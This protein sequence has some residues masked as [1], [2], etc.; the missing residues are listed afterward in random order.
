MVSKYIL[1]MLYSALI[2]AQF[3][4]KAVA[5]ANSIFTPQVEENATVKTEGE[6]NFSE[7]GSDERSAPIISGQILES[8][9]RTEAK[10]KDS[11]PRPAQP[12]AAMTEYILPVPVKVSGS[13]I[14]IKITE[15][16]AFSQAQIDA[17]IS[18]IAQRFIDREITHNEFIE[19]LKEAVNK[20]TQ[21]YRNNGYIYA[22]ARPVSTP[23][24]DGS[25]VEI[26]VSEGRISEVI[27]QGRQR[28]NL[29]YICSR[30][31]G[32][33]GSPFST[34][35][36]E[37]KLRLLRLDP[38]LESVQANLQL[39]IENKKTLTVNVKEAK[40]FA[41][42]V[43]FDNYFPPSVGSERVGIN[44][45]YQN[46]TGIGDEIVG[47]YFRT[48]SGGAE[49]LDLSYRLPVNPSNGTLQGRVAVNQNKI[50]QS[51]FEDLGIR[52][53][54][55]LYQF[56]YRQPIV[57]STEREFAVIGGF[58]HQDGQTFI[59]D[60]TPVP[61]GIGPDEKGVSRT[62]VILF[63]QDYVSRSASGSWSVRSQF[64]LG[65]GLFD[66]TT[67]N[68]PIPDGHFFKWNGQVQR[69]QQL[70]RN[71][72]LILQTDLQLT[73][74]SLLPSQQFVIGGVQSVRGY[75]QNARAGDNGFRLSAEN[76]IAVRR[77]A[78]GTPIIQ[79]APFVELGTVWNTANNPNQLPRQTFLI[80]SGLGIIWQP[81][82]GIDG[83]NIRIDLGM[84]LINLGDRGNNLQEKSLYV[85]VGYTI[86]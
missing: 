30:I 68:S 66:A 83:L 74:N 67:N 51:D 76:R 50:T 1:L 34:V 42:S 46:L 54:T 18:P 38:L 9:D 4:P 20:I 69:V 7:A 77:N 43:S 32:G 14:S 29:S 85:G 70:D 56:I 84:P 8:S 13:M 10:P 72:L 48:T 6:E 57:R 39:G 75:R 71:N 11:C 61:F 80:G 47:A 49:V 36:L 59:F 65:T 19:F 41:A 79:L 73:P 28:L 86:K 5:N 31:E 60:Q 40:P 63:G 78:A 15:I 22:E 3:A 16:T 82:L 17:E 37:E 44:L 64:N 26:S 25:S 55:K 33:T 21:L 2:V 81:F 53:D 27:I 35:E 62:S 24:T 58:T 45:R 23:I 52:G 12:T